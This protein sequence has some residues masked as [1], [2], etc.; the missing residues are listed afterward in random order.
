MN[1][2]EDPLSWD[3]QQVVFWLQSTFD[4]SEDALQ[5]FIQNDVDG[6]VLLLDMDHDAL[7]NEFDVASFGKRCKI[8]KRIHAL[9]GWL[10]QGQDSNEQIQPQMTESPAGTID[11]DLE[12]L[13]LSEPACAST[14]NNRNNN[15]T[16]SPDSL[17]RNRR[18]GSEEPSEIR[19]LAEPLAVWF[20]D[21]PF[22]Q[23]REPSRKQIPSRKM[24][25]QY[26]QYD[27]GISLGSSDEDHD[28][29]DDDD[30]DEDNSDDS[31][32]QDFAD[33]GSNSLDEDNQ[34]LAKRI[35]ERK[36]Q[37]Q[38]KNQHQEK[39][40]ASPTLN[41]ASLPLAKRIAPTLVQ[42]GGTSSPTTTRSPSTPVSSPSGRRSEKTGNISKA[43]PA[44]KK[45]SK[46]K[47]HL[48]RIG[49]S[50]QDVFFNKDGS[51]IESD[52]DDSWTIVKSCTTRAASSTEY[53]EM[54]QKHMRRILRTPPIFEVPGHLVYAP[55]HNQSHKDTPVRV[56]SASKSGNGVA[57]KTSTWDAIFRES[58]R[59][60]HRNMPQRISINIGDQDLTSINF[61]VLT[62]GSD[63][64]PAP[65]LWAIGKEE[66]DIVYPL[67][68]DSDASDYTTDE[69]L[70]KEVTKE[71]AERETTKSRGKKVQNSRVVL[72]GDAVKEIARIYI[73]DRENAWARVER[74]K[75]GQTARNLLKHYTR[76]DDKRLHIERADVEIKTLKEKRLVSLL[77]AMAETA[78]RTAAEVR[79]ACK[80][81][82]ETVD[83]MCLERWKHGILCGTEPAPDVQPNA[84]SKTQSTVPGGDVK[85]SSKPGA[86]SAQNPDKAA[87]TDETG[88]D[89]ED[90]ERRQ[91]EL[92]AAF[93]DDSDLDNGTHADIEEGLSEDENGDIGMDDQIVARSRPLAK[94]PSKTS[95]QPTKPKPT[96][97]GTPDSLSLPTPPFTATSPQDPPQLSDLDIAD[98]D[99]EHPDDDDEPSL[100]RRQ[101]GKKVRAEPQAPSPILIDLDKDD[102]EPDNH[103]ASLPT[104]AVESGST[105]DTPRPIGTRSTAGQAQVVTITEDKPVGSNDAPG[106]GKAS[107]PAGVDSP[108]ED[109][110]I[111][112]SLVTTTSR[113]DEDSDVVDIPVPVTDVK[114][115]RR[116]NWRVELKDLLA[117]DDELIAK[118]RELRKGAHL[119]TNVATNEP[120][121]SALQ[122][123]IEWIELD[124]GAS[125]NVTEFLAWKDEGNTTRTYREK[126]REAAIAQA[127]ADKVAALKAEQERKEREEQE[128]REKKAKALKEKKEKEKEKERA[129]REATA[130]K[131]EEPS[132]ESG[133]I[134]QLLK[135]GKQKVA[136]K[137]PPVVRHETIT[138]DS[139]DSDSSPDNSPSPPPSRSSTKPGKPS[140]SSTSKRSGPQQSSLSPGHRRTDL[141]SPQDM[142]MSESGTA[143][144]DSTDMDISDDA[145]AR[146]Q[147]E[148]VKKRARIIRNRFG[149]EFSE[150]SSGD[151]RPVAA[152]PKPRSKRRKLQ[153]MLDEAEDVLMLRQNAAKNEEELQRRIKDQVQRAK[154]RG[155][156]S[157]LHEGEVLIN[158]GHKKTERAV[159]IPAFLATNLKPHQI[160]G[161]RFMWK[162][163]V[164]FD[165]GCILAHS[166]GL[167]KTFQ[168][169]AFI[170]V[171]LTEVHS[172][173]KDIPE[174]LQ[175]GRVLLLMPPIVLQN[176][177]DEFNKWIPAEHRND[178]NVFKLPTNTPSSHERIKVLERWYANGGVFLL[179]YTMFRE[180]TVSK[181]T[182]MSAETRERLRG[183]L[184]NPGP[185]ITF[186]DEG[187]AI[188]NTK[189]QLALAAKQI[190]SPARVILTG[191]PLQNRLEEYWCMVDF[192]RPKFLGDIGTF[193]HNYINPIGHGLFHDS[194][195][196]EKKISA[197]KLKVLT[198]LIK[199]FVMRKD[200]SVLRASLPKKYEFVVSCKLSIMQSYLYTQ[201]LPTLGDSNGSKAIL[202]NGQILL[203]ICN[204][205]AAFKAATK[206]I[207][208][209]SEKT[210]AKGSPAGSPSNAS[211]TQGPILL[212]DSD[213]EPGE[214]EIVE[215]LSHNRPL[216]QEPWYGEVIHR[217]NITDASHGNKVKIL[218][219]ILEECHAINEKVL[220]FSR[221]IPTLDYLEYMTKQAGF[222]SLKLDGDT[223]IPDRQWMINDF[224]TS[225]GYDL[226]LISSG[227]GSQG[228]NLVS[229]SRVVIFDV[230]WNP[231]HDEQAVARAFRYGQTRKVFV[232]RLQTYGTWED[233]LYKT[234]LYKL[235]LST[236]VVDKKNMVKSYT[237]TEMQSYFEAP[238]PP[239]NTP[240]WV[241]EENVSGL[242]G[243][244]DTE[245]PVLRALIEKNS[246][247]ITHIVPQSELIR[248]VDSDLTEADMIEIQNMI[249]EEQRRIE[250][251]EK[252]PGIAIPPSGIPG[253]SAPATMSTST[254]IM[255]A[256]VA[257]SAMQAQAQARVSASSM[258]GL[259]LNPIPATS[260]A[261]IQSQVGR[262]VPHT[263]PYMYAPT[264]TS[265]P[266]PQA[267]SMSMVPQAVAGPQASSNPQQIAISMPF[268]TSQAGA[269]A[270]PNFNQQQQ[271]IGNYHSNLGNL[272]AGGNALRIQMPIHQQ[273]VKMMPPQPNMQMGY[274]AALANWAAASNPRYQGQ[275]AATATGFAASRTPGS[276]RGRPMQGQ[277]GQQ[278]TFQSV[279]QQHQGRQ[280]GSIR[281]T[282]PSG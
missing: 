2:P 143:S 90:E 245:D 26:S 257:T 177:Q 117:S 136:A 241:N 260:Y 204:H 38:E 185:S 101:K 63:Y 214:K 168:V 242:F 159:V 37:R 15:N 249:R 102:D 64:T 79:K 150:I 88:T 66:D 1:L 271:M 31:A 73:T 253:L 169:V 189:A 195:E 233:K 78:Y 119:G 111:P 193:R 80:A 236:R 217:T 147:E 228:V 54:V 196:I 198:E 57:V 25:P 122:E 30:D 202:A 254:T 267:I 49:L 200:Q 215:V 92:D 279:I 238:P 151:E 176:W 138:I 59:E 48:A 75:L 203:T 247:V 42:P 72:G 162:N 263:Q 139:S 19:L 7:K 71:E 77:E 197:K 165:G 188:K 172:G 255:Q 207:P 184:L 272:S 118:L 13:Q 224:N 160:D 36:S 115:T 191:Y 5:L 50:L 182:I 268:V 3:P 140:S 108:L 105:A 210:K 100:T 47:S 161:I 256:S 229:A 8:L 60:S 173:N 137:K 250:Y 82:D 62:K 146:K 124:C 65:V 114:S 109:E 208:A 86:T 39:S 153:P 213:E 44:P 156:A 16:R 93:I 251:G 152:Q 11:R 128:I 6:Q 4:F 98:E 17:F 133:G 252:Y 281:P 18:Q 53:R 24:P 170:Y 248:E 235:G 259:G 12:A 142:S 175:A 187:H 104:K 158:P 167:G 219:D 246:K 70:H 265:V 174:K 20:N 223:P 278:E 199:N 126:A 192:V 43:T 81:L 107:N 132:A 155:A 21:E 83:S 33:H 157:A 227:A 163:I 14:I 127:A 85:C 154:I 74:P 269:N 45:S 51:A 129:S 97:S 222:K 106:S 262:Q 190:Q 103:R 10:N 280:S 216:S 275:G 232:Y 87:D 270:F 181:S 121:I 116:P 237:K 91:R 149:D 84:E 67:Y 34:P 123:Y 28:D 206:D 234:N 40:A 205:P 22:A 27:D 231:S 145:E 171:L 183:L 274:N 94:R 243:K 226:F 266:G 61:A 99:A 212:D 282:K 180:L 55:M 112:K 164:M 29:D 276:V 56:I 178:V 76:D 261:P 9:R 134:S 194:T 125:I 244:L 23:E 41:S 110:V 179:G 68:G 113:D 135:G 240:S 58:Q 144:E 69:E 277:Q 131:D 148:N 46:K 120:Y 230:G 220:V 273:R 221:S 201:F 95:V 141:K 218:L 130:V 32:A 211:P 166:M 258:Q 209:K 239:E 35:L 52:S 186:A 89:E 264:Q 225:T 96:A